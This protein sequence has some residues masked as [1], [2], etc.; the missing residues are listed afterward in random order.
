VNPTQAMANNPDEFQPL[1]QLLGYERFDSK[2]S[3]PASD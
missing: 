2:Q 3:S 1:V